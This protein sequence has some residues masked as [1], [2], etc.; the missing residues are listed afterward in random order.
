MY[1]AAFSPTT[2]AL[3]SSR[4]ASVCLLAVFVLTFVGA[5]SGTTANPSTALASSDVSSTMISSN[6]Q[7]DQALE[8]S[9]FDCHSD[10]NAAPWN[11]RLAPS[12]IFGASKAREALDFSAWRSYSPSRKREEMEAIAKVI[13]DGSMP[14]GDYGLL[15]PSANP[16]AQQRRLVLQWAA[17]KLPPVAP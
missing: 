9:C 17:P 13:E 4:R 11:A 14:P 10:R 2:A 5:C 1:P 12:Y 16:S 3:L 7:V 15:H 6:P 8:H